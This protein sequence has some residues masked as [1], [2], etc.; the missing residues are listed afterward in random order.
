MNL[1]TDQKLGYLRHVKA[2]F[3]ARRTRFADPA[4][5][6]DT[7]PA[8]PFAFRQNYNA[9]FEAVFADGPPVP[10]AEEFSGG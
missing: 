2:S 3:D 5:F 7:L 10:V 6:V 4:A 9:L 8:N 1:S